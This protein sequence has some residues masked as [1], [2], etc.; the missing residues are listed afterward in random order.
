MPSHNK[1]NNSRNLVHPAQ[2]VAN[3]VTKQTAVLLFRP[4]QNHLAA[5]AA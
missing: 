2:Q 4:S 3:L 1:S 5:S